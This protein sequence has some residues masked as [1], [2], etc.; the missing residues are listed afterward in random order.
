MPLGGQSQSV[1]SLLAR[2]DLMTD[3]VR[4]HEVGWERQRDLEQE[5][6]RMWEDQQEHQQ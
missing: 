5:C 1:N 2:C 3:I 4:Q 6:C